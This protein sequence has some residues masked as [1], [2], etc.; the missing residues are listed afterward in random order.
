MSVIT[1][2]E[3]NAERTS[4][5]A[6]SGVPRD[7]ENPPFREEPRLVSVLVKSDQRSY[8]L[9][10]RIKAV[11][12]HWLKGPHAWSGSVPECIVPQ[13]QAEGLQVVPVVPEGHP[14]DRF[15]EREA[16]AP[17]QA[18]KT[19]AKKKRRRVEVIL[20]PA[21]EAWVS[22]RQRADAFLPAHGWDVRDITAN[23]PDDSRET[24][25]RETEKHLRDQRARVKAVRALISVDPD[26][27]HTL[28]TNPG[29]A[30]AFYA[31]HG[32]T[33]AQVRRG[34]PD[35]SPCDWEGLREQL[36]DLYASP[37]SNDWT[38]EMAERAAA[39][40]PGSE[41]EA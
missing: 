13:M 7:A 41:A 29:K 26:I 24:E 21:K 9:R 36:H 6:C 22:D 30:R 15:A 38:E 25:E 11:G 35:L 17:T 20:K 28:A 33:E 4:A 10:G 27:A 39:T 31:V 1:G 23:L 32:V 5:P 37:V 12:L 3:V 8:E 16:A 2:A 18:P 40:L 14:L 34:V 19:P